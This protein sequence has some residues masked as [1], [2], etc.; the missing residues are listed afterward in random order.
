MA[1]EINDIGRR[2]ANAVTGGTPLENIQANLDVLTRTLANRL[3]EDIEFVVILA[4]KGDPDLN[5]CGSDLETPAV[6]ARLA[7]VRDQIRQG[8]I[9]MAF[10]RD[11]EIIE[12][13]IVKAN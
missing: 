2:I 10:D 4:K 12:S 9:K 3:P 8:T 7:K 5:A 11:R 1:D 13:R 6:L